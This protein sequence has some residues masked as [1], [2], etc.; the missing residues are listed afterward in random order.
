MEESTDTVQ[1]PRSL[2]EDLVAFFTSATTA[3]SDE[4]LIETLAQERP[5]LLR[6]KAVSED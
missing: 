6:L 1:I 3:I 2:F 5:L 4:D